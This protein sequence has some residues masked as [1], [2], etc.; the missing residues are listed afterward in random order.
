MAHHIAFLCWGDDILRFGE[1]FERRTADPIAESR[2]RSGDEEGCAVASD[3]D[4][5]TRDGVSNA[6]LFADMA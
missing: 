6:H 1:F 2:G 4:H 5:P 3:G